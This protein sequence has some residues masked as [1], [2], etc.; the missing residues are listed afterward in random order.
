VSAGIK[1]LNEPV[2]LSIRAKKKGPKTEAH[3]VKIQKKGRRK[4]VIQEN[5]TDCFQGNP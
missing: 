4:S 1:T 5:R 2:I 3:F